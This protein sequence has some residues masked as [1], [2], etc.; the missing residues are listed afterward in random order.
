MKNIVS[1]A[2]LSLFTIGLA[3][4]LGAQSAIQCVEPNA[5][6]GTSVAVV[7]GNLALAH[8]AQLLPLDPSGA[9]VGKG[10]AS[11]QAEQV[12]SNL[13][14]VLGAASS[15]LAAT[16]KLN[17]YVARGESLSQVQQAIARRLL[18]VGIR[19]WLDK[20][21]LSPGDTVSDALEQAIETIPCRV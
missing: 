21:N 3:Y 13:S 7:V 1:I 19:P 12:L 17:V 6:T 20:W 11:I 15:D 4:S 10:D 8:T 18:A 2:I 9:L 16:V 5:E 14:D